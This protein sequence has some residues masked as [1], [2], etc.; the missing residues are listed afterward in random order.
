MLDAS[1]NSIRETFDPVNFSAS[2]LYII[3]AGPGK[4]QQKTHTH[5][6]AWISPSNI[7]IFFFLYIYFFSFLFWNL[8]IIIII[9]SAFPQH[10][11]AHAANALPEQL[12]IREKRLQSFSEHV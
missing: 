4:L 12:R 9:I 10:K 7:I 6:R 1:L 2:I 5:A 8:V 3:F 11:I